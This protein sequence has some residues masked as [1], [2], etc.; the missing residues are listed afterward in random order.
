MFA[1]RMVWR[2]INEQTIPLAL[3][4]LLDSLTRWNVETMCLAKAAGFRIPPLYSG[5][6][7]YIE[8]DYTSEHPEDWLDWIEV[9]RQGGGDCEDLA[10]YRAAELRVSGETARAMF[11][12]R[13]LRDGRTLFHIFVQ[14]GSGA[15]EDPSRILGMPG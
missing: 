14:R 7:R 12:R 15:L 13:P 1:P 5:I 3:S 4:L 8:E 2:G 9:L 11:H 10:C 6:V